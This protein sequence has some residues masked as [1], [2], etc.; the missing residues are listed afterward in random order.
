MKSYRVVGWKGRYL[1]EEDLLN[2]RIEKGKCQRGE[3]DLVEGGGSCKA[4]LITGGKNI[5]GKEGMS[6]L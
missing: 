6:T 1:K 3:E 5:K 2:S 4:G